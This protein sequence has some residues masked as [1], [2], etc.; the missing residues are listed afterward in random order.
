MIIVT[1][2]CMF[3]DDALFKLEMPRHKLHRRFALRGCR[4]DIG[5]VFEKQ[6][7]GVDIYHKTRSTQEWQRWVASDRR[8]STGHQ[9]QSQF[10]FG[11]TSR[12]Y[13]HSARGKS[14]TGLIDIGTARHEFFE[15]GSHGVDVITRI[16][17]IPAPQR[18]RCVPQTIRRVDVEVIFIE[19]APKQLNLSRFFNHRRHRGSGWQRQVKRIK[20]GLE[21]RKCSGHGTVRS[22][23]S[24]VVQIRQTASFEGSGET[25]KITPEFL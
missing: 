4:C 5:T 22:S 16:S 10:H 15:Y 11:S 6:L 14:M 9:K 3:V 23:H 19:D 17:C 20:L 1:G 7:D 12:R 25:R 8:A 13:R 2:I 18:K 24:E 21:I